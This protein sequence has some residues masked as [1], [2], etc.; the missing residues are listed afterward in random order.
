MDLLHM[1]SQ[2][3]K[4]IKSGMFPPDRFI[5]GRRGEGGGDGRGERDWGRSSAGQ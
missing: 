1:T 3:R 4:K 5:L 2:E